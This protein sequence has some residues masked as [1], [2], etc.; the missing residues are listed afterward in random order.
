VRRLP[1]GKGRL[2]LRESV[3]R[4]LLN[5]GIDAAHIDTTDRCTHRDGD[6]FFSHRRDRGVTGRRAALIAPTRAG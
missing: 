3:R 1:D 2:D 6:E 4:Q 5:S